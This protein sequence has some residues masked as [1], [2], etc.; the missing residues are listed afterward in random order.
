MCWQ[1]C[2]KFPPTAQKTFAAMTTIKPK[3]SARSIV[4]S[5]RSLRPLRGKAA[6][7]LCIV[8]HRIAVSCVALLDTIRFME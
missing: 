4:C 6:E 2:W 1:S 3:M 8:N 5:F 7:L